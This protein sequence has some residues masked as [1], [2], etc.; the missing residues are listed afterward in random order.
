MEKG[1]NRITKWWYFETG[2]IT[3][4]TNA[5]FIFVLAISFSFTLK[6]IYS[7]LY[8][9]FPGIFFGFLALLVSIVFF[10]YPRKAYESD[11]LEEI[12]IKYWKYLCFIRWIPVCG[13]MI[14]HSSRKENALKIINKDCEKR[15]T[16]EEHFIDSFIKRELQGQ[17]IIQIEKASHTA[18]TQISYIL[19]CLNFFIE[20]LGLEDTTKS[21]YITNRMI[22]SSRILII[23]INNNIFPFGINLGMA[24]LIYDTI[25][26]EKDS[27][28]L[29][30]LPLNNVVSSFSEKISAAK[31][32]REKGTLL[33]TPFGQAFELF[34]DDYK[35]AERLL[36]SLIET[37]EKI[38][39]VIKDPPGQKLDNF[40][41]NYTEF[42][43]SY[44]DK[45]LLEKLKLLFCR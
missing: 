32:W 7:P 25:Y 41:L 24:K 19:N 20:S 5:I 15:L 11:N 21:K 42:K 9:A 4:I 16:K 22:G 35:G 13:V 18:L 36:S 31:N 34:L 6:D 3:I 40:I 23:K 17:E 43:P 44:E 45:I 38:Q 8:P 29:P 28:G 1:L 39:T 26:P 27:D 37:S 14:L 30:V 12:L 33:K 2:I 10:N